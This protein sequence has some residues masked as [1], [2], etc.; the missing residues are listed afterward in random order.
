M[1]A[2]THTNGQMELEYSIHMD[3]ETMIQAIKESEH[4]EDYNGM[5]VEEA[6]VRFNEWMADMMARK[7]EDFISE[8][9]KTDPEFKYF[10]A[11]GDVTH[12]GGY[13]INHETIENE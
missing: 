1:N 7:I 4:P 3:H 11:D 9:V 13:G 6:A 12:E 2:T 10:N 5:T 8:L